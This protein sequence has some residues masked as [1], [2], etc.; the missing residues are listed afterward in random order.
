M[1]QKVFVAPFLSKIRP[2]VFAATMLALAPKVPIV[3]FGAIFMAVVISGISG[4]LWRVISQRFILLTLGLFTCIS[5]HQFVML[6]HG[7]IV[8]SYA[9]KMLV[10]GVSCYWLGYAS[11]GSPHVGR[12]TA[13]ALIALALGFSG[14]AFANA[15]NSGFLTQG[16]LILRTFSIDIISGEYVHK[17]HMGMYSS[18]GMCL[19][20]IAIFFRPRQIGGWCVWSLILIAGVSGFLANLATQNRTPL[21]AMAA[22]MI[23]VMLL[24]I[25]ELRKRPVSLQRVTTLYLLGIVLFTALLIGLWRSIET[26]QET[27]LLAFSKGALDTPRYRVWVTMFEH[28][29]DYFWGGRKIILPEFFAHNFWLDVLWES[30]HP[31]FAAWLVFHAVHLWWAWSIFMSRRSSLLIKCVVACLTFSFLASFMVEPIPSAS[32]M[33]TMAHLAFLGTISR[34]AAS[35]N[36]TPSGS[37]SN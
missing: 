19:L 33:Y 31:A 10:F 30:G 9:I 2:W 25:S 20:P 14:I 3:S 27:V 1:N 22:S 35:E 28:F 7:M 26:L 18:L 29:G 4:E 5:L 8:F 24:S 17:T 21:I 15:L 34:W 36:N 23:F 11:A 16:I 32:I 13:T 6:H 37:I 12:Y